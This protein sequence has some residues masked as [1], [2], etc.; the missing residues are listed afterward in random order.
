MSNQQQ[1][2][3]TIRSYDDLIKQWFERSNS[4][5]DIFTKFIFLY[6]SFI[7]FLT[8]TY[9]GKSDRGTINSLKE[10]NCKARLS[11]RKNSGLKVGID[12]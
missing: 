12:T 6:I 11:S 10:A 7:A 4:E 2:K 3:Q 1:N 9:P 5:S 8:R